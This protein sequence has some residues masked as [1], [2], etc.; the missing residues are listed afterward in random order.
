V[1]NQ[2]EV[3]FSGSLSAKKL[4]RAALSQEDREVR[5]ELAAAVKFM[6]AQAEHEAKRDGSPRPATLARLAVVVRDLE[7]FDAMFAADPLPELPGS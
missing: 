3:S 1:S 6:D 7:E 2:G 4:D 5:A